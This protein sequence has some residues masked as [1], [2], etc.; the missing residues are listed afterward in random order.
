MKW[1]AYGM[2]VIMLL[3][4]CACDNSA[5]K[6]D[7]NNIVDTLKEAIEDEKL[8]SDD[9][10][11][12]IKIHYYFF[13]ERKIEIDDKEKIRE[14]LELLQS[15]DYQKQQ[16]DELLLGGVYFFDFVTE[17]KTY[18]LGIGENI[19]AI[20]GERYEVSIN[21]LAMRIFEILEIELE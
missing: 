6:N 4:L 3:S 1:F 15:L 2:I 21:N 9:L 8:F 5:V 14:V 13:D 16:E 20:A 18:D 19:I 12:I 11:N 17:N 7:K 10:S